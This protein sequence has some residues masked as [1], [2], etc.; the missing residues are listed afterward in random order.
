MMF[1]RSVQQCLAFRGN[2]FLPTRCNYQHAR[3]SGNAKRGLSR[4]ERRLLEKKQRNKERKEKA[5]ASKGE[6]ERKYVPSMSRVT[7]IQKRIGDI[8]RL[9][10]PGGGNLYFRRHHFTSLGY[11][12]PVA[13][14]LC[15][16]LTNE[17]YFP[18]VI[19][20]SIGPSMLPTIQFIGD[21]WFIETWA[22]HRLLGIETPLKVGDVVIWK[23]PKTQ[24]V[25]CKRIIGVEGDQ[26]ARYGE[27]ALLYRDREDW[28]IVLPGDAASRNLDLDWDNENENR[29]NID[30]TTVVPAAHVWLEGDCPPFS[31]DSRHFGPIPKSWVRGRLFFRIWPFQREDEDGNPIPFRLGQERP[32]PFPSIHSYIGKRFNFY[33]VPRETE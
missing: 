30:Q 13:F 6:Q 7:H 21:L 23:D 18:Y 25:S 8:F 1:L 24:R 26:V 20:G 3:F 11:R 14:A 28:G 27:Y 33:R 2:L 5:R 4:P 19:Q 12:L 29:K 9:K 31:L 16:L 15:Y 10:V 22:W 17:E 32:V